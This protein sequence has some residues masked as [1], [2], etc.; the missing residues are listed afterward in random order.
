MI[1]TKLLICEEHQLKLLHKKHML[2]NTISNL[3]AELTE[4]GVNDILELKAYTKT[5]GISSSDVKFTYNTGASSVVFIAQGTNDEFSTLEVHLQL[6]EINASI[7]EL[8]TT[9]IIENN[10]KKFELMLRDWCEQAYL[11]RAYNRYKRI[12]INQF[13]NYLTMSD[14]IYAQF[15]NDVTILREAKCNTNSKCCK[16]E[17]N[18]VDF[19]NNKYSDSIPNNLTTFTLMNR[20]MYTTAAFYNIDYKRT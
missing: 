9:A 5:N 12:H 10:K 3:T 13:T 7:Y 11:V 18:A 4:M 2:H 14:E 16:K 19:I 8:P 1:Y 15:T 17:R 20:F 6:S